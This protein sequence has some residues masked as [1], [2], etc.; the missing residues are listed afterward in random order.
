MIAKIMNRVD[1]GGLVNYAY[2]DKS[3]TKRVLQ[4]IQSIL[5]LYHLKKWHC[6][7][8][9]SRTL[10]IVHTPLQEM[11]AIHT[12]LLPIYPFLHFGYLDKWIFG[13]LSEK[14]PL[15]QPCRRMWLW[16]CLAVC[17]A[18][19]TYIACQLSHIDSRDEVC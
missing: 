9:S 10:A 3:Q 14:H 15:A 13:Y 4:W 7:Q 6:Q 16:R 2:N 11:Q 18:D 17:L 12:R 8:L 19:N 1:F 5:F